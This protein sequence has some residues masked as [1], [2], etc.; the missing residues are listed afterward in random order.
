MRKRHGYI[1][2]K[3]VYNDI[4]N[5][6]V[7]SYLFTK[8]FYETEKQANEALKQL[9]ENYPDYQFRLVEMF[10]TYTGKCSEGIH[11]F[12]WVYENNKPVKRKCRF[13]DIDSL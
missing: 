8:K 4:T 2:E 12:V 9:Q 13:C 11:W 5:S 3:L 1:I 10:E 6:V 7:D